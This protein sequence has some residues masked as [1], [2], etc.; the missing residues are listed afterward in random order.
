MSI[1]SE[2]EIKTFCEITNASTQTAQTFLRS[3]SSLE[4]A[5]NAFLNSPNIEETPEPPKPTQR[6]TVIPIEEPKIPSRSDLDRSGT[7]QSNPIEIEDEDPF[8]PTPNRPTYGQSLANNNGQSPFEVG[9]SSFEKQKNPLI[10]EFRAITNSDEKTAE[11]FL[12][13]FKKL[14]I[15]VDAYFANDIN[16]NQN[17]RSSDDSNDNDESDEE[18]EAVD[19]DSVE[20][21]QPR[22]G[23]PY[24]T[25]PSN[26]VNFFGL[27]KNGFNFD[28]FGTQTPISNET[29]QQAR[30]FSPD[31]ERS[32]NSGGTLYRRRRKHF[33]KV[34]TQFL[35]KPTPI[36]DA[37]KLPVIL[38]KDYDSY[39]GKKATDKLPKEERWPKYLGSIVAECRSQAFDNKGSL[40]IKDPL[41][42]EPNEIEFSVTNASKTIKKTDDKGNK[43]KEVKIKRTWY[44]KGSSL[45][46]QVLHK[47]RRVG[48]L[49]CEYE[50]L[51]VF[52]LTMKFVMLEGFVLS[53]PE[54][55]SFKIQVNIF[56]TEEVIKNP[57]NFS[58][59]PGAKPK[60]R[61]KKNVKL[62]IEE[63][64]ESEEA[65]K[66]R[67]LLRLTK[68]SFCKLF[69]MLQ[70]KVNIP[71]VVQVRQRHDPFKRLLKDKYCRINAPD[72]GPIPFL[73]TKDF[74]QYYAS[75]QSTQANTQDAQRNRFVIDSDDDD[76]EWEADFSDDF[77]GEE[78]YKHSRMSSEKKSA[79]T[80]EEDSLGVTGQNSNY[81]NIS[82]PPDTFKSDLHV[83]QKQ[84]L[85]WMKYREECITKEELY[86]KDAEKTRDLHD[87]Y[88]E[89][90]LLDNSKI[91]FNPFNGAIS[92]QMP[93]SRLCKGGIL[94]DE[95]GLGKT[96]MA[97]ALI[98][99]HRR[100]QKALEVIKKPVNLRKKRNEELEE[101]PKPTLKKAKVEKEQ[102]VK[103]TSFKVEGFGFSDE[104]SPAPKK[105][106]SKEDSKKSKEIKEAKETKDKKPAKSKETL[107]K[108]FKVKSES[109]LEENEIEEVQPEKIV[110]EPTK[111]KIDL[112]KKDSF[113]DM[114]FGRSGSK[115]G[116]ESN[117]FFKD[118]DN[119]KSNTLDKAIK[120]P[121]LHKSDSFEGLGFGKPIKEIEKI[122]SEKRKKAEDE[123][124]DDLWTPSDEEESSKTLR[125]SKTTLSDKNG[126]EE[127][128]PK[129]RKLK[130]LA[131]GKSKELKRSDSFESLG[132]G[133][134]L[135]GQAG[136]LI[137][138]PLT[139]LS[140]WE[141]E[142]YRHSQENTL[143]V[144]QYYGSSRKKANL[145]DYDVVLTTYGILETEY[146]KNA[147][148]LFDYE[149]FRVILDEAHQI[150]SRVTKTSRAAC[151]LKAEY[152]WCMTG[153]PLQN[154]LDDMFSILQFLRV[155]TWGE[156]F[157]WN[158][159]INKHTTQEE[160]AEIVRG[161]LK[162]ILLR[163]TKKSTYLDGRGILELPP[164]EVKTCYVKLSPEERK[165][166]DCF[167]HKGRKQFQDIVTGGTLQYEYAHVFELLVRL[168]QVCDHPCLVFSKDDLKDP[169]SLENAILKFMEKRGKSSLL[170]RNGQSGHDKDGKPGLTP[171]FITRTVENL[172]NKE[173]EPCAICLEEITI[174]VITSCGHIFCREC[175]AKSYDNYKRCPYCQSEL[176]SGDIMTLATEENVE[177]DRALLDSS[178]ANF[179]K[180][181]KLE[182]IIKHIK[183]VRDKGEKCVV[184]SQFIKMLNLVERFIKEEG[185]NYRRIDGSSTMKNRSA[186]LDQFKDDPDVTVMMISLKAGATGLNLTVA[187]HV[188]LIDPWWNPAIEDQAIE[189]V[190][191]IGQV[192]KVNVVRFI[193]QKTIEE[194]ILELNERKKNLISLTLSYNPQDQKKQNM[195]NMIYVMQGFDDDDEE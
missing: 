26:L 121:K 19:S 133:G 178:S 47:G 80:K 21:I 82:E 77:D 43:I 135:E 136:T 107:L 90:E 11:R 106:G 96:V 23:Q 125:R 38:K 181:S 190:H 182:E 100:G 162:P 176:Q 171:E 55:T 65:Q 12:Q 70:I 186:Y 68:E 151:A 134:N 108:Y 157:W 83:Y 120:E 105:K 3:Y 81:F 142:I 5:I 94:A 73:V 111:I 89:M 166:Y 160:S 13:K 170:N 117:P 145:S 15:A 168:R 124:F 148:G 140:Q 17:S 16:P 116:E 172:K 41:T 30:S 163:R 165:I 144:L 110:S 195:E 28:L 6:A 95:M 88:Q 114:G 66:K 143:T 103:K 39:V 52:L 44:I 8:L 62:E 31:F 74:P 63:E 138:V 126:N 75:T 139:V 9:R 51:F 189:R 149:W 123:F 152:R 164:K 179:K 129:I 102:P 93:Q 32:G 64:E 79:D 33:R 37:E 141:E 156:Y 78:D 167:F 46:V 97:I 2:E 131:K 191:R 159:Y 113:D 187:Q 155:E 71:A 174:P 169:G 122:G 40:K 98:H 29:W 146:S 109:I 119:S 147:E 154:K 150:K 67:Q 69:T 53:K 76:D 112:R 137:V 175:L 1:I 91:Y 42:F 185:I 56:L 86:N 161:I 61:G 104:E 99:S 10:E 36:L 85:T 27:L 194:R 183:A 49:S 118:S 177:E 173:L 45:E 132:F 25:Q 18:E 84:A 72:P 24:S 127:W 60:G 180:S 20:E 115:T 128:V 158:N 34:N 92:V 14:E 184:F 35:P 153:T 188:F 54:G 48:Y 101:M 193:C 58:T 192:N 22:Y 87:L 4:A 130:T 7:K 57:L 50:E 59:I